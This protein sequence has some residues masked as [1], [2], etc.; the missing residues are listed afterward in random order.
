MQLFTSSEPLEHGTR[1]GEEST[2][3]L[4][5]CFIPYDWLPT[6]TSAQEQWLPLQAM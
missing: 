4:I 5:Y 2:N 1:C 3:R 6:D